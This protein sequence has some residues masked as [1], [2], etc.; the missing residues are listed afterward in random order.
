MEIFQVDTEI[1]A[2]IDT[3][4]VLNQIPCKK[5]FFM[6]DPMMEKIGMSKKIED[7]LKRKDIV[8]EVFSEIEVNPSLDS[9]K[10]A[11]EKVVE[12]SPEKIIALGGG[13]TLDSAK[14]V[15]YFMG[16]TGIELPVI[17]IPTT[18]GTGSE[19]TS[20]AVI[21]DTKNMVKIPIKDNKMIPEIAILDPEFT[22]T[23]PKSVVADGGIDALTH[24]IEAYTSKG[25]NLYTQIYALYA[26]K[27]I[28]KNL[29]KMFENI[30]DRDSRVEMGKASCI[31][32]FS[33]EKAGLGI[34]HS[35]AHNIGGKFHKAHGRAN[36]VVLPYVIRF[37]STDLETAR[38]YYEIAKELE[39][40]ANTIEEGAKS[41][42]I[43][44]EV[45]N[46]RLGIQSC[47]RDLGVE[48]SLYRSLIPEMAEVA[49]NDICTSGN[50]KR[51]TLEDM[52]K[53]FEMIY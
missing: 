41:L 40:P 14:A 12:F 20:Y 5:Y 43:A 53:I 31:A 50:L 29:L 33:F 9:I 42:A 22:K 47:V 8:Y 28:F 49:M 3:E 32:G 52:K 39:L 37:N 34:N 7:I 17:A 13:S 45:L 26:I 15:S 18:C 21:T 11:L 36:G 24:A 1:F 30:A 46:E 2:G 35:I 25:A 38:R 4:K 27:T 6:T 19:V 23:L 16:R 51:V 10:K 48:E 44:I